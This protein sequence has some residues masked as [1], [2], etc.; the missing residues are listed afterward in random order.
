MTEPK[1]PGI[2]GKMA[3]VMG[4]VGTIAKDKTNDFQHYEYASEYAIKR[5]IQPLLVEHGILFQLEIT[6]QEVTYGKDA[7]GLDK[8]TTTITA[9]YSFVDVDDGSTMEGTFCGQGQDAGDK[10]LYKAITGAVKYVLTSSF[11]IPTGDDPENEQEAAQAPNRYQQPASPQK[12]Q[13]TA[14][15]AASEAIADGDYGHEPEAHWT[16]EPDQLPPPGYAQL[17]VFAVERKKTSS[18]E[19]YLKVQTDRGWM[20][21]FDEKLFPKVQEGTIEANV[22]TKGNY[23]NITDI[24]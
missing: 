4:K 19:P 5:A 9:H 23:K 11:L 12:A 3:A 20:S 17:R 14:L 10:G 2:Y 7:K 16:D 8:L 24:S 13:G 22:T 18:G 1:V 6:N 15:K 21:V